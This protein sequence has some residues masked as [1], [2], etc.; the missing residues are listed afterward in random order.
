MGMGMMVF[1]LGMVNM[2]IMVGQQGEPLLDYQMA[3]GVGL[4]SKL[5]ERIE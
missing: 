2:L 4:G 5:M 1:D 3:V